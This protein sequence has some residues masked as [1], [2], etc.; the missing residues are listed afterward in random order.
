MTTPAVSLIPAV[1]RLTLQE[2]QF[3]LPPQAAIAAAGP[4]AL[5]LGELLAEYLRPATGLAL[6]VTEG[7]SGTIRLRCTAAT[8]RSRLTMPA[9]SKPS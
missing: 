9:A 6:P 7:A 4:G 5:A 2:G 8:S 3:A 1:R